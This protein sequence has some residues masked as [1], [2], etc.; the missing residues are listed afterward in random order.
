MSPRWIILTVPTGLVYDPITG[1][2]SGTPGIPG[3]HTLKFE[4]KDSSKTPNVI[5]PGVKLNISPANSLII[6]YTELTEARLGKAY[7]NQI[8]TVGGVG[9]LRWGFVS[10][11]LPPGINLDTRGMLAGTP[12]KK[13]LYVFTVTVGDSSGAANYFN[14][15]YSMTVK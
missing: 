10:G 14:Q 15:T 9:Q 5:S 12:L 11:T 1:N 3:T 4:I 2:L 8:V 7:S 13:G 6:L